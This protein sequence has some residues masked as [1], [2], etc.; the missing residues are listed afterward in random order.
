MRSRSPRQLRERD[1]IAANKRFLLGPSPTLD[2]SLA[3]DCV[4]EGRKILR[5]D[6]FHRPAPECV[7]TAEAPEDMLAD[8]LVQAGASQADVI[9]TV[10]AAKH[11]DVDIH[12]A[13][14]LRQAQDEGS[15]DTHPTSSFDKLRMR[16]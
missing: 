5:P 10:P 16:S 4:H 13:L 2:L 11:V 6:E 8:T 14:I 1:V 7:T 12:K 15:S 9:G 3:C